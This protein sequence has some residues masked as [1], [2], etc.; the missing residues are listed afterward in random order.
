MTENNDT[1]EIKFI[2]VGDDNTCN[3]G[4]D[5]FPSF[6]KTAETAETVISTSSSNATVIDA[7]GEFPVVPTETLEDIKSQIHDTMSHDK[8]HFL[9]PKDVRALKYNKYD[10]IAG[11]FANAYVIKNNK[12]GQIVELRASNVFHA[13]NLIGWRPRHVSLIDIINV[14]EEQEKVENNFEVKEVIQ[15][16]KA[17]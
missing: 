7:S 3:R 11:N 14:K 13:S 4:G 10:K 12:T 16:D 8:S 9:M 6:D 1:K 17:S 15:D 5:M 2:A